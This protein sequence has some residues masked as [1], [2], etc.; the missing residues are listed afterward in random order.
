[1]NKRLEEIRD[2]LEAMNKLLRVESEAESTLLEIGNKLLDLVD[3]QAVGIAEVEGQLIKAKDWST[4]YFTKSL[5]LEK[6]IAEGVEIVEAIQRGELAGGAETVPPLIDR[7]R[8]FK[9]AVRGTGKAK[10]NDSG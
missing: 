6:Q 7:M 4:H 8:E 9:N 1:M 3:T 2:E 5:M 10:S